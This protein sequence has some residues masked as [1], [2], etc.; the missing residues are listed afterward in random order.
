MLSHR[1][2]FMQAR[3]EVELSALVKEGLLLEHEVE[4]LEDRPSKAMIVWG[5]CV[6]VCVRA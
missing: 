1:L 3:G 5:W 2:V 4:L 6:C